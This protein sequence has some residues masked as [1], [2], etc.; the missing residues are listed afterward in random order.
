MLSK[1]DLV[2]IRGVVSELFVENNREW[3]KKLDQRFDAFEIRFADFKHE[4]RD[5]IH[6]V[7]NAA[8]TASERRVI[9]EITEFIGEEV[10]PQI[11][12]HTR[13]IAVINRHLKLA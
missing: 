12:E 13:Q 4:I 3:D 1:N 5:E 11:D 6:A 9:E 8:V 2:M 7:V 10:L